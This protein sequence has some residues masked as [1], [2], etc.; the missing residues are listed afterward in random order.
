MS[1]VPYDK[2]SS[3]ALGEEA[4]KA[5][6][7]QNVKAKL[8]P[9]LQGDAIVASE[10]MCRILNRILAGSPIAITVS[11]RSENNLVHLSPDLFEIFERF[12]RVH[13]MNLDRL[14]KTD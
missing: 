14:R 5:F 8:D 1:G 4:W 7:K 10:L 2:E 13:Q 6:I 11:A 3:R 12:Y 9:N